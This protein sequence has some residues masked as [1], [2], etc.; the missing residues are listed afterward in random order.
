MINRIHGIFEIE[1]QLVNQR[2]TSYVQI[3][4]VLKGRKS[5]WGNAGRDGG[6]ESKR[7]GLLDWFGESIRTA[8]Y[9]IF[10]TKSG[11]AST[12]WFCSA[13]GLALSECADVF[14]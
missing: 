7:R 13:K 12:D 10:K 3:F 8:F 2:R 14:R 5:F 6:Q 1:L 4:L 9:T 11:P